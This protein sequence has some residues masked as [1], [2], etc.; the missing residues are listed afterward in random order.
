[1]EKEEGKIKSCP[2]CGAEFTCYS[3]TNIRCWCN[4][5]V[6]KSENLKLLQEEFNG[7]LCSDCLSLYGQK[8]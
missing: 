2:R 3:N 6:I 4:D 1:M 8:K 7:C 5:Y